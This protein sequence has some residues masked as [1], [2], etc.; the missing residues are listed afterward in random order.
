MAGHFGTDLH[1]FL[2][3]RG[4]RSMFHFL[5]LREASACLPDGIDPE[6]EDPLGQRQG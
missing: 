2:P 4:R 6:A 1:H 3:Q 5:R